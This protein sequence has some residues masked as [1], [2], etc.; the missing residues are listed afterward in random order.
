MSI[1]KA[2]FGRGAR[3]RHLL[4]GAAAAALGVLVSVP[5]PAA[6]L[7][8]SVS[9][10]VTGPVNLTTEGTTDWAVWNYSTNPITTPASQTA[11]PSN[12]KA[13]VT[14]A[15]GSAT[16]LV[17]NARGTSSTLPTLTY[18]YTDGTSPTTLSPPAT[19]GVLFDTTL[20][21]TS[22]GFTFNITTGVAGVPEVV[23]LYL[24]GF[25]T[26]PTLTATLP[27]A[28]AYTD[29]SVTYPDTARPV[30]VYTLDVTPDH[31][32]DLLAVK[33]QSTANNPGNGNAN[34]DLQ[35]VTVGS[36]PEPSAA[37]LLAAGAA[38]VLA[39][40]PRRRGARQLR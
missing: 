25:G 27:G 29:N 9:T 5:A 7:T 28:T 26:T 15:I 17:G 34:A 38:G 12:R 11:G 23:K 40:R 3:R 31:T 22:A 6:V 24:S 10:T 19:Q 36:V 4:G 8:G 14:P 2:S 33:Y 13:A 30:T 16:T 18:T 32:G 1:Q 37:G 39:R 20:N 21:N 35:A